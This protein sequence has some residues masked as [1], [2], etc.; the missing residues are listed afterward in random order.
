MI[1]WS[2]RLGDIVSFFGFCLGGLSVIFM[3]KSDIRAL[4]LKLGFLQ[5]TVKNETQAQNEKID[6][7]SKEIER[8]AELLTLMGR[9][10]E[11]F[12]GLQKQIDDIKHGR[13]FIREGS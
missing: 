8:F 5:D 4:A 11:R 13:G 7:Q 10:E 12:I 6:R 2:I 1:D 3:M 9:Y